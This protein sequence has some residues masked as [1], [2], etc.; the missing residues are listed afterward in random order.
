MKRSGIAAA[1]AFFL[2]LGALPCSAQEEAPLRC[3][4]GGKPAQWPALPLPQD[5][6]EKSGSIE[7]RA[8]AGDEIIRQME[9]KSG[10]PVFITETE[11]ATRTDRRY[12]PSGAVQ[13]ETLYHFAGTPPA[14][15]IGREQGFNEAGKRIR[16]FHYDN[17]RPLLDEKFDPEGTLREK[18][19]YRQV[20][21]GVEIHKTLYHEN[22]A[23]AA[24]GMS[25]RKRGFATPLRQG[26][27]KDYDT[28]GQPVSE[29]V[30][31]DDGLLIHERAWD[32][33]GALIRDIAIEPKQ[34]TLMLKKP[35][36]EKAG[37]NA[38][39]R[40][41]EKAPEGKDAAPQ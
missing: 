12:F 30:Y 22:G 20:L 5:F 24:T 23:L 21:V 40:T 41:P 19:E 16:D 31:D 29:K 25:L 17:G 9:I 18:T 15:L 8:A 39:K 4:F 11:G 6:A 1:S 2:F 34:K 33:N 26:S 35:E 37:E 28:K 14:W 27:F 7:C 38:E 10:T 32:A 36:G 3:T 13:K